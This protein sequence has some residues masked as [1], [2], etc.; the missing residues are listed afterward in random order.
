MS[1]VSETVTENIF[2]NFYGSNTFIEKSA[3]PNKYGFKSKNQTDA[4]GYP[5]FFIERNNYLIIVEAKAEL[6]KDA[7]NDI[8]FYLNNNSTECNLLGIAIAGQSE[9]S[10]KVRYYFKHKNTA[11][12]EKLPIKDCLKKLDDIDIIINRL[13]YGDDISNK[14]LQKLLSNLNNQFHDYNIR[15]TDRSLFFSSLLISLKDDNFRAIYDKVKPCISNSNQNISIQCSNLNKLILDAV[16]KQ[17]EDKVNSNS[18]QITWLSRFSF[19]S[20]IDIPLDSYIAIIKRIENSIFNLVEKKE[21]Q[22]ILGKAY[23][24]FL[25]RAG[26][27]ENKNIIFT[28]DHIKSL[29][30]RLAR[31]NH[32]SIILDTCT[33]S[34]G[35]LMEAM[36]RMISD[37]NGNDQV[38]ESIINK[39]LIGIENDPVL[40]SLAC[41]NMFLHGDGKTNLIFRNSLL[42][43][44]IADDVNLLKY[45]KSLSPT[46]VIINPPYE[47]GKPIKFTKQALDYLNS[48]GKLII[49]MPSITLMQNIKNGEPTEILSEIL[50][51]A[52]L[53]YVINLP[54]TIFKEQ[55]RDVYPSIFGFTKTPHCPSDEVI[56][57]NI[58][59]DCLVTIQHKGRID[60]NKLW[61]DKPGMKNLEFQIFDTVTN[62]KQQDI[63]INN[64]IVGKSYIKHIFHNNHIKLFYGINDDKQDLVKFGDIFDVNEKGSLQSEKND[65]NGDFD[66]ITASEVWKKH[67]AYDHEQEAIIY[68]V[69]AEGSLGRA[70]YVN[71]KFIASNLCLILRPKN[72]NKYPIDLEFYSYYLMKI[73][74]RLIMD[75]AYGA[76]KRTINPANL[77][78]YRIKYFPYNEQIKCKNEIKSKLSIIRIKALELEELKNT[79]YDVIA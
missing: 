33:G 77:A 71:G 76:S 35:F 2:R 62:H 38:I 44:K 32:K 18:K 68:A 40:F 39:Q 28:P 26:A 69:E 51:V 10:I 65:P 17:L 47:N 64:K 34:G 73:R 55:K 8:E 63:I 22:D 9:N 12:I 31:V 75:L 60:K 1:K 13:L 14:D 43:L 50:S 24:I 48:N 74:S 6:I 49:I 59:D 7:E 70:H 21:K 27:A 41:S 67:S 16:D 4:Q 52:K 36:E 5:D 46:H 61:Y 15:D 66:F 57:C 37:A 42:D 56:F 11:K 19:I 45:I 3:I 72:P 25:A 30:V 29:M 53:D 79:A 20:N 54:K 78:E 58:E 23:K